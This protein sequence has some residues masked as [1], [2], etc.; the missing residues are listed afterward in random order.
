MRIGFVDHHLNNFHANKFLAL[1]QGPVA[2][3]GAQIVSAWES[4]PTGEDWCAR[5]GIPRAESAAA[6]AEQC[7][8]VMVL[9]PDNIDAHLALCQEVFPAGKPVVV[10]KF[11][12]T[13]FDE[14]KEIMRLARE[15][16][17]PLFSSSSLRFAVELESA[18]EGVEEPAAEAFA[19]GMGE[20]EGYG[21]HTLSLALR[22]LGPEAQPARLIDTG[23]DGAACVT[24]ETSDGRRAWIDVRA[25][26]NQWEVFPWTFGFRAGDRYVTGAVQDY[27]G[28]YANLMR[29]AIRFFRTGESPVTAEEMLSVVAILGGA[30]H[31]RAQ[32]GAWISLPE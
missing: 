12:A 25:A 26:A 32:G 16:G 2:E 7:D 5:N 29:Q 18:L 3:E 8:G 27:D 14:A 19:R 6:V 13:R 11:L 21:V 15:A 30:S 31:S 24:L 22:A 4:D 10:D 1:L 9:A 17:V 20:W 28:F 23:R